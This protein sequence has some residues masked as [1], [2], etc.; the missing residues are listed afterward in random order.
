MFTAML[1]CMAF[2]AL[3]VM[4]TEGNHPGSHHHHHHGDHSHHQSQVQTP[5]HPP[6]VQANSYVSSFSHSL[7]GTNSY[8]SV[9]RY[10]NS[11]PG[12]TVVASRESKVLDLDHKQS[13]SGDPL[14]DQAQDY[15]HPWNPRFKVQRI[16]TSDDEWKEHLEEI[17]EESGLLG[18]GQLLKQVPQGLVNLNYDIHICVHMGTELTPDETVY[19]PT[20]SYPGEGISAGK[21]H[22]ILLLDAE[23]DKLHWMVMN[24]PGAKVHNGTI[25]TAYASPNPAPNT[26]NHRYIVLV[27]E[28]PSLINDDSVTEY[29][30]E[31]SCQTR[32]LTTFDLARFQENLNLS[33]PVAA[34]YFIQKYDPFIENINGHC[35]RDVP[36]QPHPLY[37]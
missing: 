5:I 3:S 26:G 11:P 27:M 17:F 28:Q 33:E 34:N 1:L 12:A 29:K 10:F 6:L 20:I 30:T 35:L 37:K 15:F 4:E 18:N 19:P 25:V 13:H 16:E 22:T 32:E 36:I 31:S 2:M 14:S 24:I 23:L 21:F 8:M 9:T 7:P